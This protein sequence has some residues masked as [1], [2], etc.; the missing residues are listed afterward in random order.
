MAEMKAFAV[1]V[2]DLLRMV[3][4]RYGRGAETA[5]GATLEVQRL[6]QEL[7][8][9]KAELEMENARLQ[10]TVR[11]AEGA[12]EKYIGLY[13]LS[14]A[15]YLTLDRSGT[16][17]N[18]NLTFAGLMGLPRTGLIGVQFDSFLAHASRDTFASLLKREF[19]GPG[20][21]NCQLT[22]RN[23]ADTPLLVQ[24]EAATS[25]DQWLVALVDI[26]WQKRGKGAH[27]AGQEA[28]RA[29]PK[30]Q[31]ASLTGALP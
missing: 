5:P 30:S 12:L 14:P 18:A 13:N 29:L 15:S 25:G 28:D 6:L 4:K 11:D 20:R 26:T 21:A 17:R 2:D 9:Q 8:G 22:L 16:I 23:G 10:K 27:L 24:V 31:H 7:Q 19:A 3:G 1:K